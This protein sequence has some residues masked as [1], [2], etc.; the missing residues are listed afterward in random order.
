MVAA[1]EAGFPQREIAESAY[2]FQ[3][4]VERGERAIVGVNVH[5]D[6]GAARVPILS[7]ADEV[8]AIQTARVRKTRAERDGRDAAR[9][10]DALADAA[11]SG[12]NTMPAFVGCARASVTIGEMC[13]LLR[14]IWG[15]FEEAP[16]I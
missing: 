14:R 16:S 4:A 1:V 11:R 12:R 8:A 5:A 9:A 13:N 7:I 15:E 2:R 3:Q 6:D 10:L